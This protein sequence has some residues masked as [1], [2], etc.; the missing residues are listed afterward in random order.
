M[1]SGYYVY[2]NF[3]KCFADGM[4]KTTEKSFPSQHLLDHN[5][6]GAIASI[7]IAG[8]PHRTHSSLSFNK[9]K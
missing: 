5:L 2:Y 1:L 7:K 3:T 4:E 6:T 9:E 8:F